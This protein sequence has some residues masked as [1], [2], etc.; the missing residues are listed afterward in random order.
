MQAAT[1]AISITG[2]Y[3]NHPG[4]AP[5][6]E[7]PQFGALA[8]SRAELVREVRKQIKFG[9]DFIKLYT[10]GSIAHLSAE[11]MEPLAQFDYEDIKLVVDEAARFGKLVA[12][13][14]YGGKGAKDAIRAGVVSIEHGMLLDD[15]ALDLMV[16]H[17][18]Y[19]VPTIAT[20]FPKTPVDQWTEVQ[21]LVIDSHKK[22]FASAIK[23]GVRIAYGTDV[24]ALPH[25]ENT[26]DMSV[27]VEYGMS[28]MDVIRTATI[29]AADV[30]G[31]QGDVGVI[32]PGA[33]ADM[34]AVDG[35]PTKDISILEDVRYV[36]QGGD[37]IT[38]ASRARR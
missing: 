4:I 2:G 17:G 36:M 9:A 21:R 11:S 31:W 18:T 35:D 14:A 26:V 16:E 5:G 27:M 23:K 8:D 1:L 20:Y 28:P 33:Y 6:I 19:W 10:T 34:I 3:M 7:V 12:A 15:E 22:A 37:V 32:A 24:G 25:G 30:M 13:H 29:H 38:T